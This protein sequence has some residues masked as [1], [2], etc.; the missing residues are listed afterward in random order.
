MSSEKFW[1]SFFVV[2]SLAIIG[3]ISVSFYYSN[4]QDEQYIEAGFTRQPQCRAWTYEWV[5]R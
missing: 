4:R 2:L 5:R 3:I 1:I